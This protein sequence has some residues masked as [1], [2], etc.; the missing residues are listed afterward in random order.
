MV[1]PMNKTL[2]NM[3]LKAIGEQIR[4][5]LNERGMDIG[6]LETAT[7]I[8]RTVLSRMINGHIGVHLNSYEKVLNYFGIQVA[9][10]LPRE[11]GKE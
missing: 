11:E 8:H 2:E 5:A 3:T 6:D 10:T 1:N 7:N 9:M 4:R